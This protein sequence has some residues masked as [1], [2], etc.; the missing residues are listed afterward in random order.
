VN[1]VFTPHR[2][3]AIEEKPMKTTTKLILAAA[4]MS[5]L[6]APAAAGTA[7][8]IADHSRFTPSAEISRTAPLH[9]HGSVS[10]G[11]VMP[12]PATDRG[13]PFVQD[14]VHVAFP[15]CSGGN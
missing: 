10:P 4:T 6:A 15:Q 7:A 9:A 2:N 5:L 11:Q 1:S 3:I 12:G 8:G 14:C 13:V